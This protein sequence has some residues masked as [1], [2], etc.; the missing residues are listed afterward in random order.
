MFYVILN[1]RR[2]IGVPYSWYL[3]L[4]EASPKHSPIKNRYA[5]NR[6]LAIT[7]LPTQI[8]QGIL[9]DIEDSQIK[10]LSR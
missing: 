4:T 9:H 5:Y 3:R 10:H 6:Y 8:R 7:F 1:D 2:E